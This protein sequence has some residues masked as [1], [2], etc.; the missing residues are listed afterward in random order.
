MAEIKNT[1]LKGKMNQDL[2]ERLVSK[3]EYRDAMNVEVSTSE[4]ANVGTVQSIL[5]NTMV[6]G[7]LTSDDFTCV[8]SI[9]DE[10]NNKIYWLASSKD[11]DVILEWNDLEQTSSLVFVDSNKKNIN[12]ALKFPNTHITGINIIDDFLLWTDGVGEPKKIN[13]KLSKLGTNQSQSPIAEHTKLVVDGVATDELVTEKYITVIKDRP[14]SPPTIKIN[15]NK[16]KSERGIFEKVLPR[17]CYRYKYADG[18]YSAFGPFTNVVFSAKHKEDANSKNYYSKKESRNLSMSNSIDSIELMDFVPFDIPKDVVQVDLLY[19]S[20]NSNVVYSIA[21]VKR[22]DKEFY[23]EGS[24]QGVSD[25]YKG[26]IVEENKGRYLV[27]TENIY[28]ALPENQALRPWDNVPKSAKAQEIT[29]NRLVYGNYKQGYDVDNGFELSA[30]YEKRNTRETSFLEGGVESIK[31]LRDYQLGVVYGDE[32]GRETPVFSSSDSSVKIPW[33]NE[34]YKTPNYYTPLALT[35]SIRS[36]APDWAS[37]F[38][39]YIKETSGE[40]YNLL[41]DKLYIPA[42]SSEFKNNEDHVWLS[43]P[44]SEVNKITEEDYLI[45]KRIDASTIIPVEQ[46]SRYKIIDISADPPESISN[47]Y[48]PLGEAPNTDGTALTPQT[49]DAGA[50]IPDSGLFQDETHRID[51]EV[52]VIEVDKSTWFGLGYPIIRGL[53][54]NESIVSGVTNKED[55]DNLYVAWKR[56]E[57]GGFETHSKRYRVVSVEIGSAF[58]LKLA[59]KISYD[60]AI[61]AS[62]PDDPENGADGIIDGP[63]LNPNLVFS[64]FRKEKLDGEEFAGKFFVKITADDIIKDK[65]LSLNTSLSKSKFISA[66]SK[67]S[68]WY[69][70]ASGTSETNT[71]LNA[72]T[73]STTPDTVPSDHASVDG[74]TNESLE[75]EGLLSSYGKTLFIDNMYMAAANVSSSG[76]AKEAGQGI[77]ANDVLYSKAEWNSDFNPEEDT[78]PWSLDE[79]TTWSFSKTGNVNWADRVRNFIP[80]IITTD[81]DYIDGHYV[82]KDDIYDSTSTNKT[83]GEE[84]GGHFMHIS[85][86]APGK[87]LHD[88][89]FD[90]ASNLDNVDVAGENSIAG[91]L[92]GIWGGGAF[93]DVNGNSLGNDENGDPVKFIEFENNYIG[94]DPAGDAP[95]PGVGKGYDLKYKEYHERQWDP[96]FSPT[97]WSFNSASEV[98]R[99]LENF[100]KNL[101]IGKKFR[102]KNDTST[103]EDSL[104]T[105]LDVSIKHV[106]NHTPWK[107][108]WIYDD[109]GNVVRGNDS[110]EEAAVAWAKAKLTSSVD[111]ED[112]TLIN[113][114]KEFGQASNRRTVYVLRLDKNPANAGANSPIVGGSHPNADLNTKTDIEFID[115]KAHAASSF[116]REASAIFE[117]EPKESLDLNIFYEASQAIPTYLTLQN[118]SQFAPS[119]CRVEFVDLPQARRGDG[120]LTNTIHL[121]RWFENSD[122]N[123]VF[124]VQTENGIGANA[125]GFNKNNKNNVEIDYVDA[126]VRFYRPDG[127]FTTCRLGPPT[128]SGVITTS[129]NVQLRRRFIVNRVIDVSQETGLSWSNCFTFGD[130]VES[131]RV[132]DDFNASFIKNGAKAST[133]LDEPY[134]EEHRKYGLIYSGLY[135]ASSGLNNLNQFIQAE[136]ITKDLNPTYGSIQKLFSRRSDLI[137]FCE[138]RVVKI[139][140]NKDAVFNADGNPQLVATTNVLGQA[141]P[142]VG[143]YGI[144]KNPESFSSESYRAYFTDKQRGAVLRLSMDGLTPISDAGMHDFFRDE[145]PKA[146]VVLGTYDEY[147]RQYNVTFKEF[148][149]NNIIKNSYLS[150]GSELNTALYASEVV[151]NPNL[152]SGANFVPTDINQIYLDGGANVPVLN[153]NFEA[154]VKITYFPGIEVGAITPFLEQ[155]VVVTPEETIDDT[156]IN[157][158]PILVNANADGNNVITGYAD[159]TIQQ[160]Q[161]AEFPDYS[162]SGYMLRTEWDTLDLAVGSDTGFTS[163]AGSTENFLASFSGSNF[164]SAMGIPSDQSLGTAPNA[165][166]VLGPDNSF[167]F[168]GQAQD[169]S[170]STQTLS[171]SVSAAYPEAT[172]FTV[173]HGEEIWVRINYQVRWQMHWAGGAWNESG[174]NQ[175]N[176]P[177]DMD[178]TISLTDGVGGNADGFKSQS[179]ISYNV[180]LQS[181]WT[182][183]GGSNTNNPWLSNVS[184]SDSDDFATVN[185]LLND[186]VWYQLAAGESKRNERYQHPFGGALNSTDCEYTFT[187]PGVTANYTSV[188]SY[189]STYTSTAGTEGLPTGASNLYGMDYV[190]TGGTAPSVWYTESRSH[191]VKYR[192][193]KSSG[194]S[195]TTDIA[196]QNLQVTVSQ[197]SN[198]TS[199]TN[200]FGTYAHSHDLL[201]DGFA[202][203]KTGKLTDVGQT[204]VAPVINENVA[205]YGYSAQDLQVYETTTLGVQYGTLS[206]AGGANAEIINAS[207]DYGTNTVIQ[208]EVLGMET[209][210][211]AFPAT[212]IEPFA[213]VEYIMPENWSSSGTGVPVNLVQGLEDVYGPENPAVQQQS[214]VDSNGNSVTYFVPNSTITNTITT[215]SAANNGTAINTYAGVPL[216]NHQPGVTQETIN[217]VQ[218]YFVFNGVDD[219]GSNESCYAIQNQTGILVDGDWYMLDLGY[220]EATTTLSE[221]YPNFHKVNS[222]TIGLSYGVD[223]DVSQ[224]AYKATHENTITPSSAI[225]NSTGS[226]GQDHYPA[227][228]FGQISSGGSAG[229]LI[230]MPTTA[231]EYGAE[232]NVLRVVFQANAE[233]H[234]NALD[235]IQ[236]QSWANT[237]LS[238]TDATLINISNVGAGGDFSDAWVV[239][240]TNSLITALDQPVSYYS[241][242]GWVWDLFQDSDASLNT[243]TQDLNGQLLQATSQGYTLSFQV[244]NNPSTGSVEGSLEVHV[245]TDAW[246]EDAQHRVLSITDIS[247]ADSYSI[248]FNYDNQVSFQ[249]GSATADLSLAT[250][251]V[252]S[253]ASDQITIVPGPNGFSGKITQLSIQDDSEIVSGGVTDSWIF[254]SYNA[255]S[256][257]SNPAQPTSEYLFQQEQIVFSDAPQGIQVSQAISQ[258]IGIGETYRVEFDYDYEEGGVEFY[259]FIQPGVGIYQHYNST[260]PASE[261]SVEKTIGEQMAADYYQEGMLIGSLVFITSRPLNSYSLDNITMTKVAESYNTSKPTIS[262]SEDVK[263]W[264][265]FKSFVPESGV[266][267]SRKYFTF[268][269]GRAYQHYHADSSVNNFYGEGFKESFIVTLL[270]D[271]PDLVKN[272][273]TLNYEGSQSAVLEQDSLGYDAEFYN[274]TS[275]PGWS[276][277]YIKT[278]IEQGSVKEFIDKEDKWFNYIKGAGAPTVSDFNFQGIGQLYED[279]TLLVEDTEQLDV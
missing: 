272:F 122:G 218:N 232:R 43:F 204:Y 41:M 60:D 100:I 256:L 33:L 148:V 154:G 189:N 88:G 277:E 193:Y 13:I 38:K 264:V 117:T 228:Y 278:N 254:T 21:N 70:D 257:E 11:I 207:L 115:E 250:S 57:P 143:D 233:R 150:E 223:F 172:D 81:S 3:G 131:N 118:A 73:I 201:I 105:I 260:N 7:A 8:G 89:S 205:Q 9:S 173:F 63:T 30:N 42:L 56:E 58:R 15:S 36:A 230:F 95:G 212:A 196:I 47:I 158:G 166:V 217:N 79:N 92:K 199:F 252:L 59:E 152:D 114:I 97:R 128:D 151:E 138:D 266:N 17:F 202:V 31:S 4:G 68:W 174:C 40:Y 190:S 113:R 270:N 186:G 61:L 182:G 120:I 191:L 268:K 176:S 178:I 165:A 34:R 248:N 237:D 46:K 210:D 12:A 110:V 23:A 65:I 19:K 179:G 94:E 244:Q 261:I 22:K 44:S 116:T 245:V 241:N 64:I 251:D 142:F 162:G 124:E 279:P 119:G 52:D 80:G 72:P 127:G 96:T 125:Q 85:F 37:Y 214:P 104:Y 77:T 10:K 225:A 188:N 243:V 242:G 103:F 255:E 26:F 18:E 126:R 134:A 271:Q 159:V 45:L 177:G 83:Y 211:E 132:E 149:Y 84:I 102:F 155:E 170:W 273:K 86:F 49:D 98:D 192:I 35:G 226:V 163:S 187:V 74:I 136:K 71:L 157:Y 215:Y 221:G 184:L 236:L 224:A 203:F 87:N 16:D 62:N 129:Q 195:A 161:N 198:P 180:A 53:G 156:V 55:I 133:T 112:I 234:Q 216:G 227:G 160:E 29:G 107:A 238:I 69:D 24:Y 231:T 235:I 194:Y 181:A 144:S 82:W 139:L 140:A 48:L 219:D 20:E 208:E 75:W 109:A 66:S 197:S 27:T 209:V 54:S 153:P 1:F 50:I 169:G 229:R 91:L 93:T 111:G 258:D 222:G 147:K 167:T 263:G 145:L 121:T 137:A 67:F 123:L 247:A 253:Y 265:S 108:K 146:G 239:S 249:N 171:S 274:F 200:D 185:Q 276:V 164:T 106:Y 141:T 220:D 2:D 246:E 76:Y 25:I 130:G 175:A 213:T 269:H 101:A 28:A 240:T 135:N 5:G 206:T 267:I 168:P 6:S 51:K 99:E 259:Y 32:R 14:K 275:K 39:F 262:Y 183:A 90:G 78:Y